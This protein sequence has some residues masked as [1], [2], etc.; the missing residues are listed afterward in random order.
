M[1]AIM[2]AL[3]PLADNDWGM[4][5]DIGDGWGIVMMIAMILFWAT[6]IVL[7]VWLIRTFAQPGAGTQATPPLEILRRRLAHGEISPEEYDHLREK[8][9]APD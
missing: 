3:I 6:I 9:T 5:G 4:H 1:A 2:T 8:L 7:A